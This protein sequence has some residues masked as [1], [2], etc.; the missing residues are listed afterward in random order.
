[1][2][3]QIPRIPT[4]ILRIPTQIPLIPTLIRCIPNPIPRIA[5]ILSLFPIP[6]FTDSS[7][8][9]IWK[10]HFYTNVYLKFLSYPKLITPLF[11]F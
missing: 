9:Y 11:T 7:F 1:M 8:F 2:L 6:A 3:T 10:R 5:L 4:P